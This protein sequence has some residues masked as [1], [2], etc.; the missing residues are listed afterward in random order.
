MSLLLD[1]LKEAEH[2]KR[3]PRGAAGAQ[4]QA[5]PVEQGTSPHRALS[6]EEDSVPVA[7]SAPEPVVAAPNPRLA[8]FTRPQ[9]VRASA[10]ARAG[11]QRMRWLVGLLCAI[12]LLL[13]G[14]YYY[15]TRDNQSLTPATTPA[16]A[17]QPAVTAPSAAAATPAPQHILPPVVF[18]PEEPKDGV[19][20]AP[21]A[22]RVR[23]AASVAA[24]PTPSA[25]AARPIVVV[26]STTA[27]PLQSAYAA[28]Q[29]GDLARARTF[30]EQ[31]LATDASQP[32]AHLG[33]ALI[34]QSL[35]DRAQAI[36][37]FRAVLAVLP[38]QPRAWA[39]LA[40]LAS[41]AELTTLESR[42]RGLIATRPDSA[43]HFALGNNLMRQSRW[44]E[45]QEQYFAATTAA[46][47]N[48]EYRFN[49]AV[50][51]DRLGKREAA[52]THY[53]NA[54]ALAEGRPVQF[55]VAAVRTRL[56]ALAVEAP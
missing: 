55:D 14:G 39:G 7:P 24:A 40:E 5:L 50:A 31:V 49:L 46:P 26:G 28:L 18:V 48:A 25:A 21:S 33:L 12:A 22:P 2:F 36:N 34:A 23:L 11:N 45:A 53:R 9:P 42:L 10:P 6:L 54:L 27:S 19:P 47:E 17:L 43:L 52:A 37:H 44:A 15:L 8:E 16:M 1:A 38:E 4:A 51:L 30:Y 20:D 35:Q 13:G 3:N 56:A 29:A 41:D 32:D